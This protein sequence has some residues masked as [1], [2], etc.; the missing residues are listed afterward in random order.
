MKTLFKN[1]EEIICVG[2]LVGIVIL[3]SLQVF[4]RYALSDP[5]GWTEELARFLMIW[6][7]F[8]GASAGIKR[9]SHIKIELII[10]KLS[11]KWRKVVK[12]LTSLIV[13]ALLIILIYQGAVLTIKMSSIPAVT[14]PITW[15]YVYSAVPVGCAFMLF[16]IIQYRTL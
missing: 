7:V 12:T 6:L 4:S 11:E 5:I 14:L 8:F 15:Q 16:R 1:L 2:L 13:A 10:N 9:K 3:T